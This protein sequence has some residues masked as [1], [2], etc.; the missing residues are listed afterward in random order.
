[1]SFA[2]R[3]KAGVK[4]TRRR[5]FELLGA[6]KSWCKVYQKKNTRELVT[7]SGLELLVVKLFEK[8]LLVV[9]F[10]QRNSKWRRKKRASR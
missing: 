6:S 3:A 5:I 10:E 1:M 4:C 9:K 2:K 8:K 7:T